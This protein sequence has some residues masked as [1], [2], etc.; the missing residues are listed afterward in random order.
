MISQTD[1]TDGLPVHRQTIMHGK[2]LGRG[3]M[4]KGKHAG[5]KKENQLFQYLTSS[6]PKKTISK[7]GIV[8]RR[9]IYPL[10]RKLSG[11]LTDVRGILVQRTH[12]PKGPKIFAVTH[13]YSRED[14]A[15]A[16]AFAGEQSFLITNAR[17]ELLYTS[18]G[19]ALW[20]S[21]IILVDRHDKKNRHASIEKARRVLELGGNIMI[22]P[23]GVWNMSP[24][25]LVRKLFSG[26]YRI[27]RL[28]GVPVIP[29]GT[30][31]YDDICYV[32]RGAALHLNHFEQQE[33]LCLLRDT[34][35][36]L[37]WEIMEKYGHTT[38]EAILCGQFP[39]QYWDEH[40][41]NYIAKQTIY[42]NEEEA[43]AHFVDKADMDYEE[44]SGH[45]ARI[46]PNIHTAFLFSKSQRE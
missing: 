10:V 16:V 19:Y 8:L 7:H 1:G 32:S 14:V 27:A 25:L 11:P 33:A 45:L 34:L 23:E 31:V 4:C 12:L 46:Q 6:N 38:R 26:V 3:I 29:I 2:F 30:M 41:K 35:A 42:E 28:T 43:H 17:Q 24:N 44:V 15:W 5:C 40:L 39:N 37:K 36:T 13:T 20:A 9:F 22:F 18:D 21:G